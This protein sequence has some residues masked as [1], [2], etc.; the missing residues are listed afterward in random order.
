MTLTPGTR[1][2]P[3][4]IGEPLGKGGMGEVYRARDRRLGRDVAVKVLSDELSADEHHRRRFERE[5]RTISRL[6]HPNV[7][8]LFDV[9]RED[10]RD[11][12][13]MELLEGQTLE[14]RIA[15]G[16]LSVDET[17][18][19]GRQ[20]AMGVSAAH[21]SGLVHRD[22]KPANVM[23][24]PNGAKVVDFGLARD[25]PPQPSEDALSAR[26]Q[27]AITMGGA[28]VG[29]VPYMAPEQLAGQPANE[30]TDIWALGCILYEMASGHRAFDGGTP[31]EMM[32]ALLGETRPDLSKETSE[33]PGELSELVKHCLELEPDRRPA[34]AED[35][36]ETLELLRTSSSSSRVRAVSSSEK[37]AGIARG[38]TSRL[39]TL[40]A[41][42]LCKATQLRSELGDSPGGEVIEEGLSAIRRTVE[43]FGGEQLGGYGS[44]LLAGF[45]TVSDAVSLALQ[46]Q[47][48][49]GSSGEL[50]E[51]RFGIHLGEVTLGA[52]PS[53]GSERPVS[54]QAVQGLAVDIAQRLMELALPGQVLL[55][56]SASD[57]ARQRMAKGSGDVR[58]MAHGTY[59]LRGVGD[60]LEVSEVGTASAPL[61]PPP[62][63]EAGRRLIAEGDELTLGWRPA[64]GLAVPNRAHWE[65]AEQLGE[66]GYGEVW[67]AR[68][69]KTGTPRVFKF[70]FEAE[71][72]RALQR[73][74]VLFRLLK[75]SLG[76]RSDIARILDWQFDEAPY[77]LESE[78][79]EGGDLE[80][81][82]ESQGGF[83]GVPL[84]QR[85]ELVA[86][87]AE[88]VAAAHGVGVLHKDIKPGNI[89]VATREHAGPQA[90]LTDFGIG[91]VVDRGV[92]DSGGVT[93]AGLTQ[94]LLST[95][96]GSSAGTP[97]YMAPEVIAGMRPTTQ[98]DIY[99]LGVVLFQ[100]VV[101]DFSSTPASGWERRIIDPLIRDDIAAC[102]DGDPEL[103]FAS[104]RELTQR[105]RSFDRRR[106][107]L[108]EQ[109]RREIA[110]AATRRRRRWL[111]GTSAAAIG[112]SVVVAAVALRESRLRRQA[113]EDR[114]VASIRLAQSQLQQGNYTE[115]QTTLLSTPPHLRQWEWGHL[116][117]QAW[118]ATESVVKAPIPGQTTADLWDGA[119]SVVVASM[120]YHYTASVVRFT[121]DGSAI[122]Q[123]RS[124]TRVL[125]SLDEVE[126]LRELQAGR[127]TLF[128]P[129]HDESIFAE[130]GWVDGTAVVRDLESGELLAETT[131]HG[132]R[133]YNPVFSPNDDLLVTTDRSGRLRVWSTTS[134]E[135]E[136]ERSESGR[137]LPI[138]QTTFVGETEL[139]VPGSDQTVIE[140][141][142]LNCAKRRSIQGPPEPDYET[143]RISPAGTLAVSVHTRD[144]GSLGDGHPNR[145]LSPVFVWSTLDG[146]RLYDLP[147]LPGRGF[148]GVLFS[149]DGTVLTLSYR[150]GAVQLVESSTGRVLATF[151]AG[152]TTA[153]VSSW[154][155]D[156]TRIAVSQLNGPT[157]ILAPG[158]PLSA[159]DRFEGHGEGVLQAVWSPDGSQVATASFDRSVK[160]WNPRSRQSTA[161]LPHDEPALDV[162]FSADG[163]LVA[164]VTLASTSVFDSSDGDL[165]L[166]E[167][168]RQPPEIDIYSNHNRFTTARQQI[169]LVTLDNR[170]VLLARGSRIVE[171]ESSET[172][173]RLED[174]II[175]IAP[176]TLGPNDRL[177]LGT[178]INESAYLWDA[179]SGARLHSLGQGVQ[180]A[181]FSP[182]GTRVATYS[183]EGQLQLW[184]VETGAQIFEIQAHQAGG[185]GGHP[186]FDPLGEWLMVGTWDQTATVWSVADQTRR[187]TL[188]GHSEILVSTIWH[189][190]SDRLVTLGWDQS[191]RVWDLDG[192]EL[193]SI[194]E[195]STMHQVRWSPD[196]QTLSIPL[197][198]GTVKLYE[199]VPWQEVEQMSGESFE[200]KLAAW[201][202]RSNA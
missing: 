67:V 103:R 131:G 155:R 172:V 1:L 143:I 119:S 19:I 72:V 79:S 100:M 200:A 49:Q 123:E 137:V 105:L 188:A 75:E 192:R 160:L 80:D 102:I 120:P 24:T 168:H 8:V 107:E 124:D 40:V 178:T 128:Q 166:R 71:R 59:S 38:A 175:G 101:G 169:R 161:V 162:S 66:G 77:F 70:C 58:W 153:S 184:D 176:L 182:D 47:A 33:V 126:P 45:E 2:G 42:D 34:S 135:L 68:H 31:A 62:D 112:L 32:G 99:A 179:Q 69:R 95:G 202:A 110:E 87:A 141:D 98:S 154:S 22:L 94:T 26:T 55:S 150:D 185:G 12:L 111:L 39:L 104:A 53:G 57:Q 93:V 115:A 194:N 136:C 158:L 147:L 56:R 85:I 109:R 89:L 198:D 152:F 140:L 148:S 171:V 46:L 113:V 5:A 14:E 92:L 20:I 132:T 63:A 25:V 197:M 195:I 96:S 41:I 133:T 142:P 84:D 177:V 43:E 61:V 156:G 183:I 170:R 134:G 129:S 83:A 201:R 18:S 16:G 159:K 116:V 145:P 114:Y 50:G 151:E 60:A 15:S 174:P 11:Y 121:A 193:V 180:G 9:G 23:L 17:L 91:L 51:K 86:Q 106:S 78:Y 186:R 97:L 88:A 139:L 81:F 144:G 54:G 10:G 117:N 30:R 28:I 64:V 7:G 190:D 4:D 27:T 76:D 187:A 191:A 35:V 199:S 29:T 21:K 164:T 74:V 3:F 189:P 65:L 165:L 125:M 149:P 108:E 48:D 196:G 130:V 157:V 173:T 52:D 36:A 146:E 138:Y 13:V 127:A 37:T 90:V 118:P 181:Q 82:I 44:G 167:S 122:W 163:S 6:Q 73:E